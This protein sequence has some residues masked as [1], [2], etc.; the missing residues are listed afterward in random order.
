MLSLII[1]RIRAEL[2]RRGVFTPEEAASAVLFGEDESHK[3][4]ARRRVV[5]YPVS[6][7]FAGPMA[8]GGDPPEIATRNVRAVAE[9]RARSYA[10]VD[11][12]VND[13]LSS[14]RAVIRG[15]R[16]LFLGV[17]WS[18][19]NDEALRSSALAVVSFNFPVPVT[20][21]PRRVAV[22]DTATPTPKLISPV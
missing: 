10:D 11:A 22:A 21:P 20:D 5:F 19:G 9:V 1:D 8:A 18:R 4:G 2:V 15:P 12:L 3:H 14:A 6:E 13:L 16:S 17:D 7:S